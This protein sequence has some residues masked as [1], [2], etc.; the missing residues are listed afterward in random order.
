MPTITAQPLAMSDEQRRT[1]EVIARSTS[2]PPQGPSG[3]ALLLAAD[4]V[5]TNEVARRCQTTERLVRAWR[6]RFVDQDVEGVGKI[7]GSWAKIVAAR[8]NSRRGR[9]R[10]AP[11]GAR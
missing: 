6:R 4:G 7:A 1:L 2:L 5:P 8:R 3:K 11:R 9:A 10:H